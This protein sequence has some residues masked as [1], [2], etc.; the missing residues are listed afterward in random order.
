MRHHDYRW[1]AKRRHKRL[2]KKRYLQTCG[3]W[4]SE[5]KYLEHERYLDE[6][7]SFRKRGNERNGG[8]H[9]WESYPDISGRRSDAKRLTNSVIRRRYRDLLSGMSADDLELVAEALEDVQAMRNAD[10]EKIFDYWW[11]IW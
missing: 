8:Y 4:T 1:R 11:W 5:A 7:Y 10:Y 6:L 9:Y 2:Q 3:D